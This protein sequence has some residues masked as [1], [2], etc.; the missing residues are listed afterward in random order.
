MSKLY[1]PFALLFDPDLAGALTMVAGLATAALIFAPT[2]F[3]F[4]P[5]AV[6][7]FDVGLSAIE[8]FSG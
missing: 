6:G 4:I 1:S 2:P 5:L 8:C 3:R 7:L